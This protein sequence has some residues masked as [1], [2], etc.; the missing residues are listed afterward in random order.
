MYLKPKLGH[1]VTTKLLKLHLLY[2]T[3][4]RIVFFIVY[5]VIPYGTYMPLSQ[6]PQNGNLELSNFEFLKF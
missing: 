6:I 2:T 1:G 5:F 4:A 3:L